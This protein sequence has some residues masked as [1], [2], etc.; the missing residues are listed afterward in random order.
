MSVCSREGCDKKL[1]SNN[2]TGHCGSGCRSPTA[3]AYQRAK[4]VVGLVAQAADDDVM[5]RFRKVAEAVGKD[6]DEMVREYAQ[7]WMDGLR[8]TL[9]GA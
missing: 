3:P 1:N 7:A 6:P 9:G 2:T 8:E 4:D 5:V